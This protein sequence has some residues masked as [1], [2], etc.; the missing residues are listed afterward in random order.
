M[1]KRTVIGVIAA[2]VIAVAAYVVS[3][4]KEGSVEYHKRE[5]LKAFERI[6]QNT[7]RQKLQRVYRRVARRAAPP[8]TRRADYKAFDHHITSLIRLGY[9]QKAR[10]SLT[11]AAAAD[12]MNAGY[13]GRSA[14]QAIRDFINIS[15]AAP[16]IVLIIAP[17][18]DVPII[19]A[20]IRQAD[21][22]NND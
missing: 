16:Q 5:Y 21:V 1:R 19:E 14:N 20:A 8:E 4:P 6:C 2:V 10:I 7:L 11:N 9:L 3:Q 13:G 18:S 12:A 15:P 22:P 17:R